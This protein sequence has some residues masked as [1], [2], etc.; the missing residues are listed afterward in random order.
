[1][2]HIWEFLIGF[3]LS[4]DV[5]DDDDDDYYYYYLLFIIYYFYYYYYWNWLIISSVIILNPRLLN[6][7]FFGQYINRHLH[8]YTLAGYQNGL[9]SLI[10][11]IAELSRLV[12]PFL[13]DCIPDTRCQPFFNDVVSG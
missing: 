5:D 10:S 7:I 8:Q 3:D 4:Q 13:F 6:H 1:M 2:L 12:A 9:M 11:V